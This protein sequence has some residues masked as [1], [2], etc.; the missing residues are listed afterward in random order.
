MIFAPSAHNAYAGSSFPG[1][2]DAL[3]EVQ[4]SDEKD[5]NKVKK[6]LSVVVYYIQ[7][8]TNVMSLASL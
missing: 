1:L 5:W 6:E 3:Y 8:A 7:A 2:V 4:R